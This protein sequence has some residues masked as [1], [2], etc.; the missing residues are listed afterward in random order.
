MWRIDTV[1]NVTTDRVSLFIYASWYG[2]LSDE[3]VLFAGLL[4]GLPLSTRYGEKNQP[5]H[6][7]RRV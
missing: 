3:C 5:L 7:N 1:A 6:A 2:V 4:Y